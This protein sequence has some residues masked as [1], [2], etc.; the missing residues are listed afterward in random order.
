EPTAPPPPRAAA[1]GRGMFACCLGCRGTAPAVDAQV[2]LPAAGAEPPRGER[3]VQEALGPRDGEASLPTSHT[4]AVLDD[5]SS[6][7]APPG[8]SG[9]SACQ[10]EAAHGE[11]LGLAGQEEAQASPQLEP[12]AATALPLLDE[13]RALFEQDVR[14]HAAARAGLEQ[15]RQPA[16]ELL[17]QVGEE[18]RKDV[19]RF[20]SDDTL[21]RYLEASGLCR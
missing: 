14:R 20:L 2:I 1:R 8:A 13:D 18:E 7:T 10:P 21:V 4:G 9:A 5:A 15:L 3:P 16:A 17:A 19:A 11:Q 12:A 6:A